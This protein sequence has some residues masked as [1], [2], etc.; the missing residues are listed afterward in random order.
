MIFEREISGG[1][2]PYWEFYDISGS[3][4]GYKNEISIQNINDINDAMI[5][6]SNEDISSITGNNYGFTITTNEL[7]KFYLKNIET[8]NM[9]KIYYDNNKPYLLLDKDLS[10][11]IPININIIDG[12]II[13]T[14]DKLTL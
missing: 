14:F 4:Q 13:I 10:D 5:Y 9:P 1:I 7:N 11:A 2:S 12:K 8:G 6:L 3:L